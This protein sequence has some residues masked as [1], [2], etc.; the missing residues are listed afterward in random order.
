MSKAAEEPNT[1]GSDQKEYVVNFGD[2]FTVR[3]EVWKKLVKHTAC[4][5]SWSTKEH[6]I[7]QMTRFWDQCLELGVLVPKPT[8]ST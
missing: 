6:F 8:E 7:R 3:V 4:V 2:H 5:S 1:T